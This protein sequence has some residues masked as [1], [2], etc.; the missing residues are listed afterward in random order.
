MKKVLAIVV[1][2][3]VASCSSKVDHPS[4]TP[5]NIKQ[6][7]SDY[8]NQVLDLNKKIAELE[9]TLKKTEGENLYKIAVT[10]QKLEYQPFQH[11]VQVSGT[12]EALNMADISPEANGQIKKIYVAE[13]EKVQKGQTLVK[14]NTSI[15]ESAINEL[16][17]RLEL[18]NTIFERQKKLWDKKIGSEIDFLTAKNNKESLERSLETLK[19]QLDL[20]I[21]TAPFSGTVDDIFVKEGEMAMPGLRMLTLVNLDELYINAD[22]SEAYLTKVKKGDMVKVGFPSYPE[23]K[24]ELPVHRIGNVV[25][26]ANRSFNIQLKMKNHEGLIKPNVIS[27]IN[28]ND[29]TAENA[30]TVPS[31]IVKKDLIGEYI[32]VANNKDSRMIAEKKYIETGLSYDNRTMVISGL[33]PGQEVIVDGYNMVSD[34]VEIEKVAN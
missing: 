14:L 15:S 22:A 1:V 26:P 8:K 29:Y 28:I 9:E 17:T 18:A 6:Q 34:G 27:T 13:G 4:G 2:L 20:S 3:I 33:E 7:I 24:E 16:E 11:F 5:D 30:L 10:V 21:V 32:Y 12:V 19:A 23:I 31:I 25:K